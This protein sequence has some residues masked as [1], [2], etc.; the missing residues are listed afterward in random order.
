MKSYKIN[1]LKAW[2]YARTIFRSEKL[3]IAYIKP[4]IGTGKHIFLCFEDDGMVMHTVCM[5]SM[6]HDYVSWLWTTA[7]YLGYVL[8]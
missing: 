5:L 8:P 3:R 6:Y 7:M 1:V 2:D 4:E